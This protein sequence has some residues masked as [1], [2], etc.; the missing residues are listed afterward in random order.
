MNTPPSSGKKKEYIKVPEP[1]MRLFSI[2]E[3]N[4]EV[5]SQM[6]KIQE[7]RPKRMQR[8]MKLLTHLP[9]VSFRF[10]RRR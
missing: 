6:K 7:R 1:M 5:G 4:Q 3:V 2:G 8:E 10:Y 9:L